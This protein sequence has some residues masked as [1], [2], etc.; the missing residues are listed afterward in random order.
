MIVPRAG[1]AGKIRSATATR[2][3][4]G[5]KASR[6]R[7]FRARDAAG[8]L[9]ALPCVRTVS[10]WQMHRHQNTAVAKVNAQNTAPQRRLSAPQEATVPAR[11]Q[12]PVNCVRADEGPQLAGWRGHDCAPPLAASQAILVAT[13]NSQICVAA[14]RVAEVVRDDNGGIQ[15]AKVEHSDRRRVEA[16]FRLQDERE[17]LESWLR[18]HLP[19]SRHANVT[20]L[21]R[22]L[23]AAGACGLAIGGA[24]P[25]VLGQCCVLRP[26]QSKQHALDAEL[27]ASRQHGEKIDAEDSRQLRGA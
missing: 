16:A 22:S 18:S 8:A 7:G 5:A 12:R 6:R 10:R 25:R 2:G 15:R 9:V 17:G 20:S 24:R 1:A 4:S 13:P 14:R 23:H 11:C 21:A 27:R 26:G 3:L 19:R